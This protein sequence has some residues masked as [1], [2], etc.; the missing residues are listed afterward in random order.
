MGN[1]R[2]FLTE[3]ARHF[4][5]LR[6]DEPTSDGLASIHAFGELGDRA[7]NEDCLSLSF[8]RSALSRQ[9]IPKPCSEQAAQIPLLPP[10]P[11]LGRLRWEQLRLPLLSALALMKPHIC[12]ALWGSWAVA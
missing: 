10:S 9:G 8:L 6:S 12:T 5:T 4:Y 7:A 11:R 2:D 3:P 1:T